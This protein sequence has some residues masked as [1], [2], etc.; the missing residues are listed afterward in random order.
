VP[1]PQIFLRHHYGV[2]KCAAGC[3]VVEYRRIRENLCYHVIKK[4]YSGDPGCLINLGNTM[5]AIKVR[6]CGM[7]SGWRP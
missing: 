1:L 7:L 5:I 4:R 2:V 6:D 3:G